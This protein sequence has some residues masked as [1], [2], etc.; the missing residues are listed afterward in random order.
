MQRCCS[1][2]NMYITM[3]CTQT[4]YSVIIDWSVKSW[5]VNWCCEKPLLICIGGNFYTVNSYLPIFIYDNTIFNEWR[6]NTI[7]LRDL[8]F[9]WLWPLISKSMD[10]HNSIFGAY[11]KSK[12]QAKVKKESS[13]ICYGFKLIC[14]SVSHFFVI[15]GFQVPICLG[16]LLS[17]LLNLT[18]V[19]IYVWYNC[20]STWLV[21]HL[22]RVFNYNLCP[23]YCGNWTIQSTRRPQ[24]QISQ[25]PDTFNAN[26]MQLLCFP[27]GAVIG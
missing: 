9:F 14:I 15:V 2:R 23:D 22:T 25:I 20:V 5:V 18:K 8:N 3:D 26:I 7:I 21:S 11:G 19:L 16:L 10:N 12:N 6:K 13:D 27:N 4:K 1:R 17:K 24:S